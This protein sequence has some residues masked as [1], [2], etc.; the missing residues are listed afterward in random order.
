[1]FILIVTGCDYFD[2]HVDDDTELIAAHIVSIS[3]SRPAEVVI[4]GYGSHHNTC[5][6]TTGKLDVKRNGNQIQLSAKKEIPIGPTFGGCGDA[7]T[8]TYAEDTLKNMEVGEYMIVGDNTEFGWLRIEQDAAYVNVDLVDFSLII[9]PP[10]SHTEG[11]ENPT[12]HLKASVDIYLYIGMHR[13]QECKPEFKTDIDR[14]GNIINI[15]ISRVVPITDSGC[16][17]SVAPFEVSRLRSDPSKRRLHPPYNIE[18]ELGTFTKGS[19]KMII[20]GNEYL[21][22]LH[23]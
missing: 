8:E 2:G 7:V 19:Y 23:L 20:N 13:L 22:D 5:V 9:S 17:I 3:K 15:D 10:L 4:A 14:S 6:N 11:L 12:F 21:F 16:K 1:M 18:I